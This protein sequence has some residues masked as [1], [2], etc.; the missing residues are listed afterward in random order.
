MCNSAGIHMVGEHLGNG[1]VAIPEQ[2]TKEMANLPEL[3]EAARWALRGLNMLVR[4]EAIR[5]NTSFDA[6]D[7]TFA[8]ALRGALE[9]FSV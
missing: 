5:R 3:L 4:E 2:N 9:K 6:C 8:K 7:Y 1:L